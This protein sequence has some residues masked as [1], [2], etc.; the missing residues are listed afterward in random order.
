MDPGGHQERV[1]GGVQQAFHEP[2]FGYVIHHFCLVLEEKLIENTFKYLRDTLE[3]M[4]DIENEY[5]EESIQ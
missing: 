3:T 2:F 5:Q 4:V 1:P